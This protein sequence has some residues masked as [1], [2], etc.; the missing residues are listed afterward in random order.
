MKLLEFALWKSYCTSVISFF[1]ISGYNIMVITRFH[2]RRIF[3]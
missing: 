2:C 1:L 3:M